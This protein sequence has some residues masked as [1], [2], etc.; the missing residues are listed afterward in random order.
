MI[1]ADM[2]D[3]LGREFNDPIVQDALKYFELPKKRPIVPKSE[4]K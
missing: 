3:F 2:A 4:T 1:S